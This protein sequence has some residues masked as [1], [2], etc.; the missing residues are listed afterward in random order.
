M[1]TVLSAKGQVVIPEGIRSR[2][3]LQRGDRFEVEVNGESVV[4]KPLPRNPLLELRGKYRGPDSL[5]EAL[6]EERRLELEREER[7]IE[8]WGVDA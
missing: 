8:R 1:R 2:L 7:K 6:L 5:T 4:L 3:G